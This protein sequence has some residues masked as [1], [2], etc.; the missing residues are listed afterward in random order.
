MTER[1]GSRDFD[2]LLGSWNFRLRRLVKPLSGSKEWVEFE[3]HS[4]CVSIWDGRGQLDELSVSSQSDGSR[5]NALTIRLY[6]PRTQEWS[7]YFANSNNPAFGTPQKGKFA[8]GRGVFLD[9][10]I[11]NGFNVVVR[12]LWTDLETDTPKFEQA[13]SADEGKTWEANWVTTQTRERA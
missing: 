11:V 8:N 13:L 10:D 3:G 2:P 12:W 7:I 4:S 9:R 5:I 6:N 1:D